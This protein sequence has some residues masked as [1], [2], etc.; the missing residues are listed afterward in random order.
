MTVKHD[1]GAPLDASRVLV[2]DLAV[3]VPVVSAAAPVAEVDRLFRRDS[4]LRAVIVADADD[5]ASVLSRERLDLALTGP[6][7]YGRSLH[8][9]SS[10][11]HVSPISDFV[12]TNDVSLVEAA[13][14][15]LAR[16]PDV[17]Y[18]DVLVGEGSHARVVR[19]ARIFEQ[20][21]LQLRAVAFHDPLT[22]LPNRRQ[23]DRSG[24]LVSADGVDSSRIAVAYIDLDGFKLVN[25]SFG[26]RAGD[27]V[28]V[29]FAERLRACMR[30]QDVVS[31]VGGDEFA[32]LLTD[33]SDEQ[34]ASVADR[35]LLSASTPFV[36]EDQAIFLSAS[37]G[38]VMGS[39]VTPPP[40]TDLLDSLL[41]AADSAMLH[42]KR[43]G[44]GRVE[45]MSAAVGGDALLR[46][47]LL[48]R[49][50][51]EAVTHGQG[52]SLVYQPTLNLAT[53]ISVAVEALLRWTDPELGSIP[54]PEFIGIAEETDQINRLGRWVLNEACAQARRW[55]SDG[56]PRIVSV[57]VSP[58]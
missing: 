58:V 23:L 39:D 33:V 16:D 20:L 19:V 44:K 8:S 54:T 5:G 2:G 49:K 34:A 53:G 31:R 6:F 55:L 57:N 36:V 48:R 37:I 47:G 32:V 18:E 24:Q 30:S 50:L 41:R 45:R 21:A 22:S 51:G 56:Q 7:G 14:R 43:T 11:Q 42:A 25:D 28:L 40:G 10:V 27:D 12:L 26:H 3:A 29:G 1:A 9:R 4:G 38:L 15:I 13:E 52:L 17:R 46:R 35:I